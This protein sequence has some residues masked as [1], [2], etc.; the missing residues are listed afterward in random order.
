M[1]LKYAGTLLSFKNVYVLI[2]AIMCYN[3]NEHLLLCVM[4]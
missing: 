3:S 1:G 4:L 2:E